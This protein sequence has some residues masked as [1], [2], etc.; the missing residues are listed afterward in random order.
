M[1]NEMR[2]SKADYIKRI[3]ELLNRKEIYIPCTHYLAREKDN[4]DDLI[5]STVKAVKCWKRLCCIK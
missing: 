2:N 4:R 3:A 1:N 5:D